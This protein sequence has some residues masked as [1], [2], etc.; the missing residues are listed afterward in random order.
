MKSIFV[1]FNHLDNQWY[2]FSK[3]NEEQKKAILE[4]E[5]RLMVRFTLRFTSFKL[6]SYHKRC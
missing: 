4:A 6:Y 5:K 2:T 1:F 3:K